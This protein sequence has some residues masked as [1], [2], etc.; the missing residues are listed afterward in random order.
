MFPKLNTTLNGRRFQTIVEVQEN[1]VR[2]LCAIKQS[3]FHKAFQQ[4]KKRLG[5]VYR[6]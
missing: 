1:A 3:T 2:E 6:Q 4:W 5:T